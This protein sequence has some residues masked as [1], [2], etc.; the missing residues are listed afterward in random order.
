MIKVIPTQPN[1]FST[2]VDL[3]LDTMAL[4]MDTP[5]WP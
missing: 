4:V 3:G 2:F 5:S 1:Q